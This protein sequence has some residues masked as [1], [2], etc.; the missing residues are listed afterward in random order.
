MNFWDAWL[1]N[2]VVSETFLLFS[3]CPTLSLAKGNL[4]VVESLLVSL[5]DTESD[6][7]SSVDDI[8]RYHCLLN[9]H[10]RT[11][12]LFE[13]KNS[14]PDLCIVLFFVICVCVFLFFHDA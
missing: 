8:R 10:G 4:K 5:Y 9:I 13:K 3:N 14:R 2:S 12:C 11:Y 7:S 6:I 1:K